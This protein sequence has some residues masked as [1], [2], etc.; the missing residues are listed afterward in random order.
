VLG[1]NTPADLAQA[2]RLYAARLA[3]AAGR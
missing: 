1:V 3:A 2:E